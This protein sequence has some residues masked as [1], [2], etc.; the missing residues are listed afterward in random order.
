[1]TSVSK[2]GWH[3]AVDI[4]CRVSVLMHPMSDLPAEEYHIIKAWCYTIMPIKIFQLGL[5]EKD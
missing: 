1:V 3:F 4:W 2:A 5:K